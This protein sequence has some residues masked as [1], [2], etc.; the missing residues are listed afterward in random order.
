VPK[1]KSLTIFAEVVAAG[2]KRKCYHAS[3][4]AIKKGD[5]CLEV[6]DGMAIKGYCVPCAIAMIEAAGNKLDEL[7]S[8]LN[9]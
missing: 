3:T 8:A 7:K 6:K 4:H 5:R 2:R 9:A 1:H